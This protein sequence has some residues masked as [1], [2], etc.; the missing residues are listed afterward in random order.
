MNLTRQ[1]S[2]IQINTDICLFLRGILKKY[3]YLPDFSDIIRDTAQEA[4][5]NFYNAYPEKWTTTKQEEIRKLMFIIAKRVAL[6]WM[7]AFEKRQNALAQ[8]RQIS[9]EDDSERLKEQRALL[10]L[11]IAR[12]LERKTLKAKAAFVIRVILNVTTC[13]N[14]KELCTK[15]LPDYH[16]QFNEFLTYD[17]FRTLKKR[18]IDKITQEI[19]GISPL[20]T[21]L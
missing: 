20:E 19:K 1:P 8:L 7:A 11:L 5:A 3:L 17:N 2:F 12:M 6:K 18:A 9:L 14:D 10:Q 4:W 16:D 21:I 15:V 13:M